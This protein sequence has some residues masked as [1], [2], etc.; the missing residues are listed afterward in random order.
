MS[1]CKIKVEGFQHVE[2]SRLKNL[3]IVYVYWHRNIFVT[4]HRFKKTGARPLISLSKDGELVAQI[5]KEFGMNPIR[6]SSSS[7]GARAFIEML[8]TIRE[9]KAEVMITADGPKGPAKEVKEGTVRLA[10]K[11]GALLIPIAW[12]GDRIKIFEK[13]WDKFKIPLPF[14]H[15]EY[16]YGPPIVVPTSIN[17]KDDELKFQIKNAIDCLE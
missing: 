3:P 2:E 7:G 1:T 15:V 17:A 5:A 6:G 10:Q 16:I 12:R 4:I 13:T 11:T 9:S 8:N 14:S